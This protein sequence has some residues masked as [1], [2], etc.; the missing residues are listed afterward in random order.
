MLLFTALSSIIHSSRF[1]PSFHVVSLLFRF[2]PR[3]P[4]TGM[5]LSFVLFRACSSYLFLLM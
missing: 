1:F 3:R 4:N 2:P 5:F